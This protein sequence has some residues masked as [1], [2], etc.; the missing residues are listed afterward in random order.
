M[1]QCFRLLLLISSHH[2]LQALYMLLEHTDHVM[3][4]AAAPS[5][6]L[7]A[8]AGLSS[9]L[10]LWDIPTAMRLTPPAVRHRRCV[11]C[12]QLMC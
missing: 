8:S 12:L 5:A 3:A 10:M 9:Q 1:L 2:A 6:G 7:L 11:Q 4:L